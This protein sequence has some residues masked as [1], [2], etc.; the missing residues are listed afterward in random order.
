MHSPSTAE[1]GAP[2][3]PVR[4]V[5]AALD[6]GGSS[7]GGELLDGDRQPLADGRT[8]LDV[9]E[10]TVVQTDAAIQAGF[11]PPAGRNRVRT[12]RDLTPC[13]QMLKLLRVPRHGNAVVST[14]RFRRRNYGED[15]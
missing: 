6:G 13:L 10:D 3:P 2:P 5:A 1:R 14:T 11:L 15:H 8:A 9:V 12:E 4:R 7:Q